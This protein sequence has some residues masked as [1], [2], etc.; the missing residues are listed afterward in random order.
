MVPGDPLV[1]VICDHP[2][3]GGD[4][5]SQRF[6]IADR[7]EVGRIVDELNGFELAPQGSVFRCPIS[8]GPSPNIGLFFD[9]ADGDVLTVKV[10]GCPVIANGRRGSMSARSILASV[11][12]AE[13]GVST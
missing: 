4:G 10:S 11:H 1:L 12:E 13:G 6:V 3:L 9:Y 2:T 7:D 8:Y 5:D